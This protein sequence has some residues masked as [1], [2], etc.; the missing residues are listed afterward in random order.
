[1]NL[2]KNAKFK[3]ANVTTGMMN[4]DGRVKICSAEPSVGGNWK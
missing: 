3:I 4:S 1:M 2:L